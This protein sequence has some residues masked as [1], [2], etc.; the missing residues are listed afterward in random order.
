MLFC[1][2]DFP[3]KS[4]GV[5]C[6]CLLRF[7]G[8]CVFLVPWWYLKLLFTLTWVK[9]FFHSCNVQ[10]KSPLKTYLGSICFKR[11][12]WHI[13]DDSYKIFLLKFPW[14]L[15]GKEP[16]CNAGVIGLIPRSGRSPGVGNGNP[17]QGLSCLENPMDRGAW[18][19]TVCEVTKESDTT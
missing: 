3:G 2:W 11:G 14:W 16:A 6:R 7:C 4:N 15:C 19:A 10:P 8:M 1:P 13:L 5:R 9:Y 12:T 17:L 18:Q